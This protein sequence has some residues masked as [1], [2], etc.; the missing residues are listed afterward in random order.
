MPFP[1]I[2]Y[3]S[4]ADHPFIKQGVQRLLNQRKLSGQVRTR[5][6]G[7]GPGDAV[8]GHLPDSRRRL[9]FQLSTGD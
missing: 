8:D 1:G 2:V 3:E 7:T 4:S 6:L 5:D 9:R